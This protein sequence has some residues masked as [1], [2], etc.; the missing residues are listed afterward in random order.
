VALA[1]AVIGGSI[2]VRQVRDLAL[3]WIE[4][5]Y[6]VQPLGFGLDSL[7]FIHLIPRIDH[8]FVW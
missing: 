1:L 7:G 4:H 2:S 5:M 6:L 3:R 8:K